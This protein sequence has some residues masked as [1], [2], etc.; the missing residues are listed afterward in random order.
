MK[1]CQA[2]FKQLSD[3]GQAKPALIK[4]QAS[5]LLMKIK[6][7]IQ[8][9]GDRRVGGLLTQTAAVLVQ[10]CGSYQELMELLEVSLQEVHNALT[11]AQ[12]DKNENIVANCLSWI[13]EHAKEDLT[14]ERAA[15]HFFFN[16]SYF[17][18]YIKNKTGR[19]FS[20]HVT[21]VRM[22][23]AKE[24]L[25]ENRLRIYEISAECGY[26]DT[27]YFC[28][29][30]KKHHGI[31]PEA[32]SILYFRKGSVRNENVSLANTG[33]LY[34]PHCDS[35]HCAR[36]SLLSDES[37]GGDGAS[38]EKCVRDREEEQCDHGYEAGDHRAE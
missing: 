34:S 8:D 36:G 37:A 30:F 27:K 25:A 14:L 7:R 22:R 28:R 15:T 12:Q 11:Q 35:T 26:Q 20:E 6:S 16:P 5:L 23:R 13:Q 32:I 1:Q 17:S 9:F 18:T 31:S 24:L 33:K 38:A 2:A 10:N 29:V 3:A 4:E 19:T 21:A